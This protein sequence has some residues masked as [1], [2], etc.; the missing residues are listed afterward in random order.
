M[1][2][3]SEEGKGG[4]CWY[5]KSSVSNSII[6][7]AW[8]SASFTISA[9]GRPAPLVSS[10]LPKKT[11]AHPSL[12]QSSFWCC[13]RHLGLAFGALHYHKAF[14]SFFFFLLQEKINKS[15]SRQ[16]VMLLLFHLAWGWLGAP[17][18]SALAGD[19]GSPDLD[20]H[21]S[22]YECEACCRVF[23]FFFWISRA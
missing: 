7:S 10:P 13:V 6:L 11:P 22:C 12:N 23:F 14:K 19:H 1:I 16:L 20:R 5:C 17:A 4:G 15:F 2:W 18:R 8:Q 3:N 21:S 9:I